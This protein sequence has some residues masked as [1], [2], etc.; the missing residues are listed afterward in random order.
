MRKFLPPLFAGFFLLGC[1]TQGEPTLAR[2]DPKVEEMTREQER[3]T[4][5]MDEL[6]RLVID[7]NDKLARLEK[8]VSA[9]ERRAEEPKVQPQPPLPSA[10]VITEESVSA[11][12]VAPNTAPPVVE[13]VAQA[14]SKPVEEVLSAPTPPVEA[15]TVKEAPPAP[16]PASAVAEKPREPKLPSGEDEAAKLYRRAYESRKALRFGRA[17]L[18]FEEFSSRFPRHEFAD[19]AQ[20]SIGESY[21]SNGQ[22][23]QAMVEFNRV[24]ERFP[25]ADTAPE[26]LY[27]IAECFFRLGQSERGQAFMK[28]LQESYPASDAAAR[29]RLKSPNP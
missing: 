4:K 5:R 27:M 16:V 15:A 26:S 29:A 3:L 12:L 1:A 23:E 6:A 18:D 7:L 9:P 10:P 24:V 17:I 13:A 20:F 25:D 28:K 11:P 21:F 8:P 14:P 22:Y 2:P 19:D